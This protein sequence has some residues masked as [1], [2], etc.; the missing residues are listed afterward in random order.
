[1]GYIESAEWELGKIDNVRKRIQSKKLELEALR[2][3]ASGAGAIQYDKEKVQSSASGDL[4]AIVVED[5][6]RIENEIEEEEIELEKMKKKAYE[7]TKRIETIDHRT[8]IEWI[9]LNNATMRSAAKKM[10]MSERSIY[11]LKKDALNS[12]G[13][14]LAELQT[15]ADACI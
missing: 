5:I 3:K 7:V 8:F 1:M 4:I 6:I 10:F 11:D 9:Y 12:F 13:I 2:Y 14:A 15:V